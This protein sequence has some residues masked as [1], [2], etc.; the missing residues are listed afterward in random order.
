MRVAK[1][2]VAM[3]DF[4]AAL[5]TLETHRTSF[6]R[7]TLMEEAEVLR[8]QARVGLGDRRSAAK[9]A[10]RFMETYPR[11]AYAERVSPYADGK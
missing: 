6:P 11:S 8:I 3:H 1:A 7:G 5:R 4:A 2:Q 10:A 9:A